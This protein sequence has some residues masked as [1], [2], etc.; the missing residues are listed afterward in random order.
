MKNQQFL[1]KL[2]KIIPDHIIPKFTNQKDLLHWHHKQGKL[3][4]Q[5]IIKQNKTLEIHDTFKKSGIRKLYM[6]CSF[7]NYIIEHEGHKKVVHL[8]KKYAKNFNNNMSSF[9]FLGKPG[10]GK[11]HLAAAISNYLIL[12]G[13]KVFMIT[14][15]DLMSTIKST[16]NNIN[17]KLT[18]EKFIK[19]LSKIDL[20][21]FDE[22]GIQIESKYEKMII[23]QIIEH[24]SA[25]KKPTGML[26]NLNG[27]TITKIL[28]E[29]IIDRMKLGN[30][31]WLNFNW[32]SYRRKK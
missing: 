25:S 17:K 32:T 11:N 20:L 1:K 24:R 12:R 10:T 26:S 29:N 14:I 27:F 9:V 16:F 18:E 21:I 31:L 28:G 8:A 19:Y 6:E 7:N 23:N 5:K 22:I 15:S 4:S 3:L 13:K 30:S 2:K